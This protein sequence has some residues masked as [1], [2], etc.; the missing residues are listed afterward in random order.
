MWLSSPDS[1]VAEM[2]ETSFYIIYNKYKK[3]HIEIKNWN[4]Y[5]TYDIF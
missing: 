5:S 2:F 4:N 3:L 1:S